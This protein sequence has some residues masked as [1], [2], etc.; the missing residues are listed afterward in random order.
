MKQLW[1]FVGEDHTPLEPIRIDDCLDE[2]VVQQ[3]A[4]KALYDEKLY[5]LDVPCKMRWEQVNFFGG[6][7]YSERRLIKEMNSLERFGDI[8]FVESRAR[9]RNNQPIPG[10]SGDFT[11]IV[12]HLSEICR[13]KWNE[14]PTQRQAEA[15]AYNLLAKTAMDGVSRLSSKDDQISWRV[16]SKSGTLKITPEQYHAF[17]QEVD[18]E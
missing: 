18:G 12:S 3:C 9:S 17:V 4:M 11:F 10:L 2:K 14:V 16:V 8:D 5:H 7:L 15:L 13:T 1:M 6:F